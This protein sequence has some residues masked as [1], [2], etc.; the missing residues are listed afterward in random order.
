MNPLD[1]RDP[2]DRNLGRILQLHAET[3]GDLPFLLEDD[4]RVTF[5]EANRKVNAVARGL[6][7]LGVGRGDRIAFYSKSAIELIYLALAANKLGAVWIPVNTDYR[8]QWLQDTLT[9]SAAKVVVTDQAMAPRL[10]EVIDR[11]PHD[12]VVLLGS[13]P[14]ALPQARPFAGLEGFSDA[15]IDLSGIG[16]GDVS[17]VLWTSGTTGKSKG[18]MQSHNAW[19]RSAEMGGRT[20]GTRP[21]DVIYNIMP[22]YNSAAWSTNILRALVEGVPVALDGAF[23][24]STFWDRIRHYNASQTFTLGAMHI[25]L[26]QAPERPDDRDNP[27]RVAGMTPMPDDLLGPFCERFGIE[28]ITQGFGQSEALGVI[29]RSGGLGRR[30]K[31]GALGTILEDMEIRLIDDAGRDVP[32][33]A[34]GEFA[35]R[36]KAPHSIFEGYF[37]NPDATR[38]AFTDDGWYRMGDLGRRDEDGDFFFVD[39]KKDAVRYKG[40]N[41]ST[42]EVEGV[43]RKHPAVADVAAFGIR[44]SEL[45]SE[46]ELKINVILKPGATLT[47]DQLAR[48]IN[49]NA[50]YYFV[51]RYIE[52]VQSLPYTPTNKVQKYQLREAGAPAGCWDRE[53]NAFE[54]TR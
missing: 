5:A 18:V 2:A 46:D 45:A 36:P 20:M 7:D 30:W 48:Y 39:R 6:A 12:H 43:V 41:I 33:G 44:S 50:P 3:A 32:P 53:R 4:R 8:G 25:F 9:D 31:P 40:R 13:G 29:G 28:D 26:W 49:D 38:A 51:P 37:N 15:E 42:M 22:M 35:L 34:V 24:V 54:L 11:V 1:L 19:I 23:S 47:E 17:A 14:G 27:L 52:F 16:Y 21:G 10:A